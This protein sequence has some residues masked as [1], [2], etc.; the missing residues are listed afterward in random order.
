MNFTI[1]KKLGLGFGAVV[2]VLLIV[3]GVGINLTVKSKTF[4][5]VEMNKAFLAADDTLPARELFVALEGSFASMIAAL[6]ENAEPAVRTRLRG[7][8]G[9]ASEARQACGKGNAR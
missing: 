3:G 2:L 1:A 9:E 6:D 5:E 8:Q 7:S 4:S